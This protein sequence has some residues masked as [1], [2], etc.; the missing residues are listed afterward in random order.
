VIRFLESRSAASGAVALRAWALPALLA[1]GR[2]SFAT[3]PAASASAWRL[4][5]RG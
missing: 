1:P 3:P 5:L 4:F 2:A